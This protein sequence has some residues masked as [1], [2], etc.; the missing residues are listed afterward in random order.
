[1]RCCDLGRI[2]YAEALAEQER[3]VA[4]RTRGLGE[5]MLLVCEHEPVVTV[6]RGGADGLG[7]MNAPV[8]E[9]SR[10]GE[11]TWHG[12]GQ[13]VGY[14]I[15]RLEEGERDLHRV[16]RDTEALVID[17]LDRLGVGSAGPD[18]AD[19]ARSREGLTGVWAGERKV[20]SIGVAV[21]SWVTFHG[22]ALNVCNDLAPFHAF[23]PCGL[24]GSLMT[25]VSEILGR[26][27]GMDEARTALAAAAADWPVYS[28]CT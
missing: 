17:V 26:E 22:F 13:L 10:G 12:P 6:G 5:D 24:D 3:L 9:I 25:S 14:P 18:A 23:R 21:R 27:V 15:R 16:L 28:S 4:E 2:A 8:V 11:A 7:K 19:G 1:M 20:C